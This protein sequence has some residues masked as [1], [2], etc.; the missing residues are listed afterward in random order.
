MLCTVAEVRGWDVE[1]SW[2]ADP[3][4]NQWGAVRKLER[5]WKSFVKGGHVPVEKA[6]ESK[7]AQKMNRRDET[8]WDE[9]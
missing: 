2:E 5:N 6:K 8:D 9:D 3:P 7:R 4:E 1:Q